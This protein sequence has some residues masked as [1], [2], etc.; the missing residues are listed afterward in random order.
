MKVVHVGLV[1]L[2]VLLILGTAIAED[3][4]CDMSIDITSR[5]GGYSCDREKWYAGKADYKITL[6]CIDYLADCQ[7]FENIDD[8]GMGTWIGY[9]KGNKY[10]ENPLHYTFDQGDLCESPCG[11]GQSLR[12]FFVEDDSGKDKENINR[13][14]DI[15]ECTEA[16]DCPSYGNWYNYD[17]HHCIHGDYDFD[18]TN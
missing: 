12:L 7:N 17:G 4:C 8:I 13:Y 18:P 14:D 16:I 5:N 6:G 2:V 9:M 10:Y 15:I 11:P 1:G 3:C